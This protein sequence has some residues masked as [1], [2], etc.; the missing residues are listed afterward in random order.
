MSARRQL[1]HTTG[2]WIALLCASILAGTMVV[3]TSAYEGAGVYD[4][5]W[6]VESEPVDNP[7]NTIDLPG[8]ETSAVLRLTNLTEPVEYAYGEGLGSADI[9]VPAGYTLTGGSIDAETGTATVDGGTLQLR[10]LAVG[11]GDSV[12][13][14]IDVTTPCLPD[15]DGSAWAVVAREST[16]FSGYDDFVLAEGSVAPSTSRSVAS[17]LLRFA[18]QPATTAT[19][20]LI[21]DAFDSAGDPLQV[22]IYDPLTEETVD[23]DATVTLTL[24]KNPADGTL[25]GG[26]EDAVSGV[27]TFDGLSIDTPGP[28]RLEASSDVATNTPETGQFIVADVVEECS[29]PGCSFDQAAGGASY[30]T[31]PQT[32]AAG[33][34]YAASLN[35]NGLRISCEFAPFDYPDSRQPNGVWYVYDDGATGS[36][37]T[38]VI[39]IPASVVK[40]TP[41]NGASKYRVCYSSPTPFRDRTGGMAPVDPWTEPDEDGNVGP[42]VYFGETWYTGLLPDCAKKN[43]VAPCVLKWNSG[44]GGSRV[45]TFLTPP[46][47]PSYR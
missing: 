21:T 24:S 47:D 43:P 9:T 30:T 17:C 8:G 18:N 13:V 15:A 38:N 39:V 42:S 2:R 19:D 1:R 6:I 27:A 26:A 37:K 20:A 3:T 12:D 7:P 31:T 46:G 36:V 45:G 23:S 44:G 14:T 4:A 11:P 5:T 10:D 35:L 16:D 22:E 25:T 34:D 33:A 28:Y 29:G 40:I 41:E 32:G